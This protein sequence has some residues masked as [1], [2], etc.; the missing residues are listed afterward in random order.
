MQHAKAR[1]DAGLRWGRLELGSNLAQK[2]VS[3]IRSSGRPNASRISISSEERLSGIGGSR[4]GVAHDEAQ[5]RRGRKGG[6]EACDFSE[7]D[8]PTLC[9]IVE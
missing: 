6:D 3:L 8:A 7:S 5:A 4:R 1:P 2:L 9:G